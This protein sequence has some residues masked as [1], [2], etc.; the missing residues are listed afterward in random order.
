MATTTGLI[1]IATT[2]VTA[3]AVNQAFASDDVA[4]LRII[5]RDQVR[6]LDLKMLQ[7]L[8]AIELSTSTPW[9]SG[10]QHFLGTPLQMIVQDIDPQASLTLTAINDYVVTMDASQIS[11]DYPIVAFERNGAPMSV[12]DKGPFWLVYPFDL[13]TEFQTESVYARSIWQ[14]VE[15]K[16]T[17]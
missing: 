16:V 3:S 1:L 6:L 12:R 7:E 8:G 13:S 2:L 9:T 5:D 11:D 10:V 15:I 4:K 14:L 17:D